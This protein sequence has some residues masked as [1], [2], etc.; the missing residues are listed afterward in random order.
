[1]AKNWKIAAFVG[2]IIFLV[3]VFLPVWSA[4]G[5]SQSLVDVYQKLGNV[6]WGYFFAN[7]AVST[8]GLLL[9]A[10]L[11]PI[12]LVLCIASIFRHKAALAAGAVGILC[13]IGAII[14][15]GGSSAY[16][17]AYGAAIYVGYAGAII[18]IVA[19]FIKPRP[20]TPLSTPPQT[21]APPSARLI[22]GIWSP[23][24]PLIS[25]DSI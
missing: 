7:H 12:S 17:I 1:M 6:D 23:R 16:D 18:M 9:M 21:S 10:I 2:T 3:S 15:I 19:Y 25:A 8:V 13:W 24:S 4:S 22:K 11:W 5:A 20:S 14:W